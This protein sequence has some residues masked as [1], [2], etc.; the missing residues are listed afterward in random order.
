MKKNTVAFVL[1]ALVVCGALFARDEHRHEGAHEHGSASLSVVTEGNTVYFEFEAPA[2]DIVGF[3]HEPRTA[4]DRAKHKTA[5]D[6]LRNNAG[7]I[8]L[9][10]A[11][12]GCTVATES[13]E[14]KKEEHGGSGTH[15]VVEAAFKAVCK[16]PAAGSSLRLAFTKYFPTL[17]AVRVTVISGSKQNAVVVRKDRPA[18]E[19]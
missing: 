7:L 3:E 10:D 2:E 8:L 12:L 13:V 11:A 17:E 5:L 4:A 9:L 18:V 19:L 1:P 15:S 16:K 6:K 14:W